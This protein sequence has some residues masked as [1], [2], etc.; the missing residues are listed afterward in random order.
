MKFRQPNGCA[1][2]WFQDEY[3]SAR[4]TGPRSPVFSP[5]DPDAVRSRGETQTRHMRSRPRV[6]FP[7]APDSRSLRPDPIARERCSLPDWFA[8]GSIEQTRDRK[9]DARGGVAHTKL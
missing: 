9:R 7:V 6:D 1:A 4:T 3:A 8:P 2:R 5:P